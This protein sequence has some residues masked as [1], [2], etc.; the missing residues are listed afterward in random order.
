MV[1]KRVHHHKS[2]VL[3]IYPFLIKLINKFSFDLV[4]NFLEDMTDKIYNKCID[5]P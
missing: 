3:Y 1:Y 2:S 4:F 5:L